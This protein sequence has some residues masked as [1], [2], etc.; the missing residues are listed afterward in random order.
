MAKE[1]CDC[2]RMATYLYMPGFQDKENS[3]VCNDCISSTNDIGCSCNFRSI[4]GEYSN[5]PEGIEGKDWRYVT[6]EGNEHM[7][8]I[9]KEDG[10]WI[11]LDERGRPYPCA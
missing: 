6:F 7:S 9:T 5:K 2:G 1:K 11:D 8:K 3:F 10:I 4:N